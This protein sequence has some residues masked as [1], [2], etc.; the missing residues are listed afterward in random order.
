MSQVCV[1][2]QRPIGRLMAHMET[3]H[4]TSFDR[5][6]RVRGWCKQ[7]TIPFV[8]MQQTGVTRCLTNRDKFSSNFK[9]FMERPLHSTP[10]SM[11]CHLVTDCEIP[12]RTRVPLLDELIEIPSEHRVDRTQRQMGGEEKALETLR[13]F[14]QDRGRNF[15]KGISSPNSAWSS[16]SRLSP[17]LKPQQLVMMMDTHF[18]CLHEISPRGLT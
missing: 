14:L 3:G 18:D 4:M 9:K 17:Y 10:G 7:H 11:S 1:H 2:Q 8:E 12:G 15:S 13:S 5:D 6:K 16:C